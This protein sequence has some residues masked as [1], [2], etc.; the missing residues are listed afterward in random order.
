MI[1]PAS[2]GSRCGWVSLRL[3]RDQAPTSIGGSPDERGVWVT[4][5]RPGR[6][7]RPTAAIAAGQ[8]GDRVTFP[9]GISILTLWSTPVRLV[10]LAASRDEAMLLIGK[11]HPILLHFPIGLLL[12][13]A[14]AELLAIVARRPAWRTIAVANARAGAAMAVLTAIAGWGLTSAPFVEASRLLEW[15]RWMGLCATTTAIGAALASGYLD[16]RHPSRVSIY[17]I[18]LFGAAALVGAAAHLGGTLVWG[19]EFLRP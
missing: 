2:F 18:A 16:E 6:R 10:L 7:S 12:T 15:H 5:C 3:T 8:H 11:L 17:R 9:R 1:S 13:A 14:A 19:A 4:A